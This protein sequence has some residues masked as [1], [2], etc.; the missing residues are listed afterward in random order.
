[1][2][3]SSWRRFVSPGSLLVAGVALGY[4][5]HVAQDAHAA[6]A[7]HRVYELRTY[8]TN[9]GKLEA[10]NARFRDNTLHL[11]AKHHMKSVAYWM[12]QDAPLAGTTLVYVISH[13]SRAAAD[14]NW[15]EF[16]ADPE[17]R[18]V[19]SKSEEN[20]KIVAKVERVFMESTEYSPLQ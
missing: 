10:L 15:S 8:T 13:D 19:M 9:P 3:N 2:P 5:F 17:V 11:F 4:G 18:D 1:M 6:P 7:A 20:G 12:P 14:Q 16:T